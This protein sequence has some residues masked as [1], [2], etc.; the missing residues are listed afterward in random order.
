MRSQ[1][2]MMKNTCCK[3]LSNNLSDIYWTI[4]YYITE[5]CKTNLLFEF[6]Y[7]DEDNEEE[8]EN[9]DEDF[10]FE[11]FR[12][13]RELDPEKSKRPLELGVVTTSSGTVAPGIVLAG[14][15]GGL[16]RQS[17]MVI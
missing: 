2:K 9:E 15:L 4:L 7:S 12:K 6:S 1:R 17:I 5:S 16:E 3:T 8:N 13:R 10:D 11:F 14:I